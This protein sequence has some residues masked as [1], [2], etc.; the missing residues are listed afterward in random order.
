VKAAT[1]DSPV[2]IIG[3]HAENEHCTEQFLSTT[4]ATYDSCARVCDG[5]CGGVC[6]PHFLLVAAG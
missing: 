5:V 6:I 2:L 4:K 3:T 1:K